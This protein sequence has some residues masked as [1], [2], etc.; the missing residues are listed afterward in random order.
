MRIQNKFQSLKDWIQSK[1]MSLKYRIQSTSLR[2]WVQSHITLSRQ[3]S[4]YVLFL[5]IFIIVSIC[6][7]EQFLFQVGVTLFSIAIVYLVMKQ[8]NIELKETTGKQI[9]AFVDNLQVVC[10]ELKNVSS[11]IDTLSNVMKDVQK[12]ILKSTLV[13]ETAMA[14]E[15]AKKRR[16]KESIKPQ[17]RVKVEP[18]GKQLWIFGRRYYQ[19]TVWNIG[20]NAIGTILTIGNQVYRAHDNESYKQIPIDIG[21][22]NDFKGVS[23]L[24]ILIEVGDVD[25]NLYRANIQVSLP[26][27]QWISVPLT[28]R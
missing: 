26:Q 1:S 6:F 16:R 7:R 13:S 11:R 12:T 14:K 9:K 22:V 25:K 3:W 8:S 27:P 10:S 5:A 23:K 21:H 17:L 4:L 24:N 19:L 20:Y 28:E 2:Q 18:T 15:E